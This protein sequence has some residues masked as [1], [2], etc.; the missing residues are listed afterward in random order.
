M[1][2]REANPERDQ[3]EAKLFESRRRVQPGIPSIA[4]PPAD[5][6]SPHHSSYTRRYERTM[7]SNLG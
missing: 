1:L 4:V 2:I 5:D 3:R 6:L 7:N